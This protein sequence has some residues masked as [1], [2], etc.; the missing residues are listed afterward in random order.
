MEATI[1]RK[2]H[3]DSVLSPTG[4]EE[5]KTAPLSPELFYPPVSEEEMTVWG[6]WLPQSFLFDCMQLSFSG[7]L[8]VTSTLARL[9]APSEV[10][11]EFRWASSVDLF[12]AYEVRTPVRCDLQ[13]PLLL[14]RLGNQWYRLALWGE[15]VLPLE[16]IAT[17]VRQ[18]LAIKARVSKKQKIVGSLGIASGIA[19]WAGCLYFHN[20]MGAGL[21]LLLV[22]TVWTWIP[23][24]VYTPENAQHNFLDRY[25]L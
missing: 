15:S 7:C 23:S 5:K 1:F 3:H 9:N 19:F 21:L 20:G 16:Q 10:L 24:V 14:G 12:E 6:H 18:S 4:G 11:E 17:L 22:C 13:D 8:E 2:V 25:R